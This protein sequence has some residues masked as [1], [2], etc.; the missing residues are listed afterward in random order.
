MQTLVLVGAATTRRIAR[1]DAR[2]WLYT[3]RSVG[4]KA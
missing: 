2:P 1:D 4:S 3:P